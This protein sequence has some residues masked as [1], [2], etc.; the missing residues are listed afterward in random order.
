MV[1]I[2]QRSSKVKGSRDIF[3]NPLP[4][5]AL[6]VDTVTNAVRNGTDRIRTRFERLFRMDN[7]QPAT[8]GLNRIFDALS[9]SYTHL[10]LPTMTFV[11][12]DDGWMLQTPSFAI[13]VSQDS[14]Y[15]SAQTLTNHNQITEDS[16]LVGGGEKPLIA[17]H[18]LGDENFSVTRLPLVRSEQA[19]NMY[20]AILSQVRLYPE[21]V[22]SIIENTS[23]DSLHS[24][25]ETG[26]LIGFGQ[27]DVPPGLSPKQNDMV[28]KRSMWLEDV[29]K[30]HRAGRVYVCPENALV[31]VQIQPHNHTDRAITYFFDPEGVRFGLSS[32]HNPADMSSYTFFQ[33][34]YP[35]EEDAIRIA[36]LVLHATHHADY[37]L[38]NRTIPYNN[39]TRE[40][41]LDTYLSEI[42]GQGID[43]EA[44]VPEILMHQATP[45]ELEVH[46]DSSIGSVQASV[47]HYPEENRTEVMLIDN[48]IFHRDDRVQHIMLSEDGIQLNGQ[49]LN[50]SSEVFAGRDISL[51]RQSV[52]RLLQ[53]LQTYSPQEGFPSG[54]F[55]N[56]FRATTDRALP[57][58]L[59][60][61]TR[62]GEVYLPKEPYTISDL[63]VS[64]PTLPEAETP[65]EHVLPVPV[66]LLPDA[67]LGISLGETSLPSAP[68]K[69][70]DAS[71]LID[72]IGEAGIADLEARYAGQ[73]DDPQ[74]PERTNKEVSL[75]RSNESRITR[76]LR[77]KR[78][79]RTPR[80]QLST[81][82]LDKKQ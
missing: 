82:K 55:L 74:Q 6:F 11:E 71:S 72:N 49:R 17:S 42:L 21:I 46:V 45:T 5:S 68:A 62:T 13:E 58:I 70:F 64:P 37:A 16:L 81:K 44:I 51:A 39:S 20:K 43:T 76:P 22:G 15:V 24:L 29:D 57:Y 67:I 19:R 56:G 10:S 69:Q 32:R 73:H 7:V 27:E 63:F 4:R 1:E 12:R 48:T 30:S 50:A 47:N 36:K 33:H 9:S 35:V 77:R 23:L 66:V 41:P 26:R 18:P 34:T 60:S 75:V 40:I 53:A 52:V 31:L 79:K 2:G 8:A 3:Q 54:D 25:E 38:T 28:I 65:S 14:V 80:T 59:A 61:L 78:P